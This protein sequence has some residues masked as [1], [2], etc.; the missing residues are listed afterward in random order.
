[1]QTPKTLTVFKYIGC[2]FKEP[3]FY[4]CCCIVVLFAAVAPVVIRE[5]G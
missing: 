3:M 4:Y 1:M 5:F 2:W